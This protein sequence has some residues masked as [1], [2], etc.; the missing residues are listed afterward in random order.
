MFNMPAEPKLNVPVTF[1]DFIAFK[2]PLTVTLGMVTGPI[3]ATLLLA[4]TVRSASN[5]FSFVTI[6]PSSCT[7]ASL[8]EAVSVCIFEVS[9]A[10]DI[11]YSGFGYLA[12]IASMASFQ[13][14]VPLI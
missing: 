5:T 10:L 12:L 11:C 14:V 1:K 2:L 9:L 13:V 6:N 7:R 8:L 4:A 3:T